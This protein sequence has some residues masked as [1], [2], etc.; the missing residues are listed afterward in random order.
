MT[1]KELLIFDEKKECIDT[2]YKEFNVWFYI[3]NRVFYDILNKD[4]GQEVIYKN[5]K[6]SNI[7]KIKFIVLSLMHKIQKKNKDIIF[8]SS[9]V[10]NM[11]NN[12]KYENRL[13]DF[14]YNQKKND[15]VI[16]EDSYNFIYR[17]PRTEKVYYSGYISL[18]YKMHR[19]FN[20]SNMEDYSQISSI[21]DKLRNIFS[22]YFDD[23]YWCALKQDVYFGFLFFDFAKDYYYKLFKKI[24]PKIVFR[25]DAS[26]G[27]YQYLAV[28]CE[29]L[30]IKFAEFQ[31]GYVGMDH[32]AY[33]YGRGFFDIKELRKLLPSY[34]LTFGEYWQE[35]II[36]PARKVVVGFPFLNK[37]CKKISEKKNILIISDGDSP[38][39]NKLLID[40]VKDYAEQKNL[41][42]VLKL[43]PVEA[44]K[45]NEWYGDLLN[46]KFVEIK[47][48]EPVYDYLAMAKYVIGS[49]S[50]VMYEAYAFEVTPFIYESK[51]FLSNSVAIK[52]FN[53]FSSQNELLNL[54]DGKISLKTIDADYFFSKSWKT[55]YLDFINMIL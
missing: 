54:M 29:K 36:H 30:N 28:V 16:I 32:I 50:T 38:Q 27:N 14:F 6:I 49:G 39:Q 18:L 53:T 23:N 25:E 51:R 11:K 24:K 31:H 17:R 12:D 45:L 3:R 37:K 19:I 52:L 26:Y 2:F 22:D 5:Q 41:S 21:V 13:Y 46:Q 8:F 40:F 35:Q 15:S 9:N 42:I 33:N 44:S 7:D 20:K 1:L 34:Y 47:I 43:H 10:V 55:N 4:N 48:F